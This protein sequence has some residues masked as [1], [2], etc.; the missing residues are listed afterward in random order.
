MGF[1]LSLRS[2]SNLRGVH[3]DLVRVVNRAISEGSTDFVVIEGLR[4]QQRQAELLA[5]GASRT[6][7]SRHLTGHAV[8]LAVLF[9]GQISWRTNL[10]YAL[11]V[12]IKIAATMENVP[13]EWG[14]EIWM[15]GFFDGPHFQLPRE[16]YP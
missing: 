2:K 1:L 16:K 13:I 6:K 12:Q 8:D 3:P 7:N 5:K 11:A 10:Y 15:P 4:S 9:E 14:G